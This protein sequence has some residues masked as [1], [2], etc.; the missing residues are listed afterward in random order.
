MRLA[1]AWASCSQWLAQTTY[2]TLCGFVHQGD[3]HLQQS[4]AS[5]RPW[6]LQKSKG[7]HPAPRRTQGVPG[8]QKREESP[9]LAS[10]GGF[11]ILGKCDLSGELGTAFLVFFYPTALQRFPVSSSSYV[12]HSLRAVVSVSSFKLQYSSFSSAS[13]IFLTK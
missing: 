4:T 9:P 3:S 5:S 12:I 10:S 2:I 13:E 7:A 8:K 6:L 11:G 1:H